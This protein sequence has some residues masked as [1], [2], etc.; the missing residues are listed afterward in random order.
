[1]KQSLWGLCPQTPE[2]FRFLLA[3]VNEQKG[4]DPKTWALAD[5]LNPRDRLPLRLRFRRAVSC[6]GPAPLL[7]ESAVKSNHA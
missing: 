6:A 4:P 2:V 5:M 7:Q 3:R 1:M